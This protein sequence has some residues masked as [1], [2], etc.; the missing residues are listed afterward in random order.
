M[1]TRFKNIECFIECQQCG[2]NN[3]NDGY[4]T[5]EECIAAWNTRPSREDVLKLYGIEKVP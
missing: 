3:E 1:Q 2:I 5:D 4:Q